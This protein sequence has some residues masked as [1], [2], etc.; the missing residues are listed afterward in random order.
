MSELN[1]DDI[2]RIAEKVSLLM[3]MDRM[4]HTAGTAA[5]MVQLAGIPDYIASVFEE[6]GKVSGPMDAADLYR[7]LN[8]RLAQVEAQIYLLRVER[9]H[10]DERDPATLFS[11]P[12]TVA[13]YG[14]RIE[15]V[16]T[17]SKSFGFDP[18]I[19]AYGWYPAEISAGRTHRWMRP[20]DGSVACLPHLGRVDQIVEIEG[21]VLLQEQLDGLGIQAGKVQAEI[22]RDV[23]N[24]TR[25]SARLTLRA[26]DMGASS[27]LPIEFK[28]SDFRTPGDQD[29]RLLGANI[30]SFTCRPWQA[31]G[32]M[33]KPS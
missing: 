22:T 8:R 4:R 16:V 33:S 1:Q 25:F 13:A 29:P 2:T 17:R 6:A 7:Q 19:L 9:E 11:D 32:A 31:D 26:E 15:T 23:D 14:E 18:A 30:S 5:D 20:G 10:R 28:L 3:Q 24:P 27:Y 12:L 21:H